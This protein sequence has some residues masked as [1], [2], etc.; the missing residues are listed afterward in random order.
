MVYDYNEHMYILT[1]TF[2][3]QEYGINLATTL[4][5]TDVENP[6]D[7]P[8]IWLKRVSR[9]IY[10]KLYSTTYD[11]AYKEFILAKNGNLRQYIQFWLG[12]QALYMLNNGDIGLQAGISYEKSSSNDLY[13]MRGDRM[14]SP[15]VIQSMKSVGAL[16]TGNYAYV[17]TFS[18]EEDGY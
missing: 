12:E 6:A 11:R 10:E 17:G 3:M 7:M 4:E 5:L 8:K 1:P 9:M 18:Y 2:I 16:Y 13:Q 14:Y 15:L